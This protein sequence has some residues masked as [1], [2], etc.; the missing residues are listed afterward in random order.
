M[1][2]LKAYIIEKIRRSGSK[3]P[4]SSYME[5]AL[6][7]PELGYYM[8]EALP[9]GRQGD[10]ITAPE[11]SPLFGQCIAGAVQPVLDNFKHPVILEWGA[12]TGKLAYTLLKNCQHIS[13]YVIIDIS[14][15]L[16]K[17]QENTLREYLPKITWLEELPP[18][19]FEG[20]ILANEVIDAFPVTRFCLENENVREYYVT[21][22]NQQLQ[23]TLEPPGD[24]QIISLVNSLNLGPPYT[25]EIHLTLKSF[26]E[27]LS[28]CL[29]A[30]VVLVFDYG[31]PRHEFYH[32]DRYAGTLMCHY[33]HR[34]NADPFYL[35]GMQDITAHVD[36][37]ALAENGFTAGF[38]VAGYTSQSAFLLEC[39]I[40]GLA[41]TEKDNQAIKLLTLP[42]EMGELFKVMAFSKNYDLPIRGFKFQDRRNRL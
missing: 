21:E 20:I 7:T 6:Y 37:T 1:T 39:G 11:L 23:W 24:P 31:F 17:Q 26:M 34:A 29:N 5:M 9:F 22:N 18:E 32:P 40:L 30:G 4:F 27:N 2:A 3:I 10:F 15:S 13:Q 12:G 36:F 41:N 19:P 28:G 38:D 35:P 8:K 14:P 33:Q 25:S 16:R 42:H